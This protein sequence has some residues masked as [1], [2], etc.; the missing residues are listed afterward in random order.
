[1]EPRGAGGGQHVVR[2]GT[3]V[4]QRLRGVAA[5]EDGAGVTDLRQHGVRVGYGQLQ[6][7]RCDAV[8]DLAGLVQAVDLDQRAAVLDGD[9]DHVAALQRTQQS[10]QAIFHRVQLFG[11]PGVDDLFD[12]LVVCGLRVVIHGDP[13]LVGFAVTAHPNTRGA[14]NSVDADLT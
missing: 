2:T 11:V 9:A 14:G 3:V 7:L 1:G 4:A 10:V 12:V 6:V 5:H 8:G 13:G